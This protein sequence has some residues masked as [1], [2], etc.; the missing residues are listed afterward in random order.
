MKRWLYALL[1]FCA[2]FTLYCFTL[3]P[4]FLWADSSKLAFMC[5]NWNVISHSDGWDRS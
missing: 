1:A 4:T 3:A 2:P 5:R